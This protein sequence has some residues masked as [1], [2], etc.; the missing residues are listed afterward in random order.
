MSQHYIAKAPILWKSKTQNQNSKSKISPS[1]VLAWQHTEKFCIWTHIQVTVKT[2]GDCKCHIKWPG[3]IIITGL[4]EISES[5]FNNG[6]RLK[7]CVQIFSLCKCKHS[8]IKN[9]V[10]LIR[11]TSDPRHLRHRIFKPMPQ[12]TFRAGPGWHLWFWSA[13]LFCC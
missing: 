6:P 4:H 9:E 5:L 13:M 1:W 2:Q 8:E 10:S 11:N 12:V 3:S 7:M